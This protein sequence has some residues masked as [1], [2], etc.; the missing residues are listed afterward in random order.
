MDEAQIAA[1][2][3][4]NI[5]KEPEPTIAPPPP[6]NTTSGQAKTADDYGLDEM[7]TYKLKDYFGDRDPDMNQLKYVYA[8]LAGQVGN[9]YHLI[10]AKVR[11][12]ED[13]MAIR[14]NENRIY[15]LYQWLKLDTIRKQTEQ[16]MSYLRE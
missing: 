4:Q 11:E 7:T 13:I 14:Y 2:L 1:S 5:P 16:E 3:K 9:D 12:L 10:M 6:P 8:E 15:K